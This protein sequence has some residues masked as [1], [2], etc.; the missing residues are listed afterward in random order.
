MGSIFAEAC[1]R[2]RLTG[3]SSRF[4]VEVSGEASLL[5][6]SVLSVVVAIVVV[7]MT[8]SEVKIAGHSSCVPF[9]YLIY[10]EKV[11]FHKNIS[12]TIKSSVY[13]K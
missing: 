3:T 5:V 12:F 8:S 7:K 11:L 1:R 2:R 10:D 9:S 6:E 4:S 13:Q